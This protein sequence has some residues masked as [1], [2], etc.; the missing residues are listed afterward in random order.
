M[1][2]IDFDYPKPQERVTEMLSLV[3]K[4]GMKRHKVGTKVRE[5]FADG[6]SQVKEDTDGCD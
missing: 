5:G 1:L 4:P 6:V 3:E 2:L